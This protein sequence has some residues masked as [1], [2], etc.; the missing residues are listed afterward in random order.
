[1]LRSRVAMKRSRAFAY[2]LGAA[3]LGLLAACSSPVSYAYNREP[4]PRQSEY[5]IGPLDRLSVVVWKNQELSGETTVRPDGI[6]SLPLIGAVNAAGRTPTQLE[7]EIAKRYGEF[8][9]A[10]EIVVAVGVVAVNSYSFSVTGNVEH[11][12]V[13]NSPGYLT[14]IDALAMAGGP[15]RFA[16]DR[17]YIVRGRPSRRIPIDIRRATSGDHPEE[18][19]VIVRGDIIVVP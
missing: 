18:N 1:M 2:A 12:G 15:N 16:G 13:F 8:L 17:L 6:M 11:A 3:L 14:A 7:K 19:L 9:R 5:V 4:D 10:E